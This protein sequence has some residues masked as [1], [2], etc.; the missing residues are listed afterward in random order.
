MDDILLEEA[1]S[2]GDIGPD[3]LMELD[4]MP[5]SDLPFA[6]EGHRERQNLLAMALAYRDKRQWATSET[7]W[8]VP[9]KVFLKNENCF[10]HLN[11]VGYRPYV[12]VFWLDLAAG[13]WRQWADV[14][15]DY[16]RWVRHAKAWW[17]ALGRQSC[18]GRNE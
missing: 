7:V 16:E 12:T 1:K 6:S 8:L 14:A 5:G 2:W 17:E 11:L 9:G 4:A 3:C 15:A 10:V 13:T 18:G